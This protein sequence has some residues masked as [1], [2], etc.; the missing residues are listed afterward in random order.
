MTYLVYT[1]WLSSDEREEPPCRVQACWSL[2]YRQYRIRW[3]PTWQPTWTPCFE[4]ESYPPK[5]HRPL[6]TKL[7][8]RQPIL[9]RSWWFG[10]PLVSLVPWCRY[11]LIVRIL[12][13]VLYWMPS[14]FSCLPSPSSLCSQR[15]Q[16]N[17]RQN[18][19]SLAM[20]LCGVRKDPELMFRLTGT[21]CLPAA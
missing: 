6:W 7:C 14:S 15:N 5:E 13:S 8:F 12:W 11:Y 20:I 9:G 2:Q 19:H 17:R 10:L 21:A 16:R 3:M 18:N 4:W 1:Y